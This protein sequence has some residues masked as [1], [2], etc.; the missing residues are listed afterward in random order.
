VHIESASS[1]A[2]YFNAVTRTRTEWKLSPRKELWFRAEDRSHWST[3]LQPGGLRGGAK[4]IQERLELENFVYEE[5]ARC[6]PQLSDFHLDAEDRDWDLYFLMQHHGVPTRIL[7]WTDGSLIALHFVVRDKPVPPESDSLV[8]IL[9]AD[10][11]TTHLKNHAERKKLISRWKKYSKRHP[12][13]TYSDEWERLYL[14]C[15]EDDVLDPLLDTTNPHVV[16]FAS[17][18]SEVCGAEEQVH[19]FWYQ[20]TLIFL[21]S[22]KNAVRD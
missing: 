4:S 7:D 11:L 3:R 17:R 10:W 19:D 13:E 20:T 22:L 18:H 2:E 16:G 12:H 9:D 14:P 15:D 8:Y 6:A 5:F 21:N 1:L